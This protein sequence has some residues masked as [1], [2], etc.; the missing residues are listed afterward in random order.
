M[1]RVKRDIYVREMRKILVDECNIVSHLNYGTTSTTAV[2]TDSA[3]LH[4]VR[5]QT[6]EQQ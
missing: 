3:V 6:T 1:L 4:T 5:W 2:V